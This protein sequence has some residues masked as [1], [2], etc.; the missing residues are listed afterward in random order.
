MYIILENLYK[1]VVDPKFDRDL[2]TLTDGGTV[3]IDW[4]LTPT[5]AGRPVK[6]DTRPILLL[7]PGIS[8]ET[9]NLY[10]LNVAWEAEKHGYV[11]GTVIFRGT[12]FVQ[13]TSGK[14]NSAV[15]WPD[16]TEICDYV[17][18]AYVLDKEGTKTRSLYA[19]GCSLG[20][21]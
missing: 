16:A 18:N 10:T 11:C 5:G 20:A 8:G 17:H 7:Y 15:S 19:Y 13:I 2:F 21:Q 4:N 6:G 1:A 9:N 3:G 12:N 14:L